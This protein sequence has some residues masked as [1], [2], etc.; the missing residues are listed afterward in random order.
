MAS[1]IHAYVVIRVKLFD[2]YLLSIL[3]C[4]VNYKYEVPKFIFIYIYVMS[5]LIV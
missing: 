4:I 3:I 2:H 5:K 1:L